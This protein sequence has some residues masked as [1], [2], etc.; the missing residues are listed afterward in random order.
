M[1]CIDAEIEVRVRVMKCESVVQGVHV[2]ATGDCTVWRFW[3]NFTA[4]AQ[5]DACHCSPFLSAA[6]PS[7]RTN[8][9]L[10]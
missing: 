7:V 10:V 3:C 1:A 4:S 5:V 9:V 2:D 6:S 8:C